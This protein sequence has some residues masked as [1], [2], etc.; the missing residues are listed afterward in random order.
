[1][2][3]RTLSVEARTFERLLEEE[4]AQR[5][6]LERY[7]KILRRGIS[8][9]VSRATVERCVITLEGEDARRA[10][11]D[12]TKIIG[13]F[14]NNSEAAGKFMRS[15]RRCTGPVRKGV[16]EGW[17]RRRRRRGMRLRRRKRWR[18]GAWICVTAHALSTA[19]S[20]L[21]RCSWPPC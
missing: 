9:R 13:N 20:T 12:G 17:R 8:F 14:M 7:V 15:P 10:Q 11:D 19:W 4:R 3:S 6:G 16:D 18:M 21:Q 1:M 2:L 5:E